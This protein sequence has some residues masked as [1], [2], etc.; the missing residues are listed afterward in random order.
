MIQDVQLPVLHMHAC[1]WLCMI[2]VRFNARES[3]VEMNRRG[4]IN[5]VLMLF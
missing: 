3:M 1:S 4:L 2:T 5:L